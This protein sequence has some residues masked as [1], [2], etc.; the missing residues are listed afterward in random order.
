MHE[1]DSGDGKTV[2][3]DLLEVCS[4]AAISIYGTWLAL[5]RMPLL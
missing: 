4:F 5:E 2:Y 3:T 1:C